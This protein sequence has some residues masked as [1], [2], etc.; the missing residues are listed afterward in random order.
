MSATPDSTLAD[1]EQLIADLQRQLAE[2][3]AERDEALAA[4]DRDRRG[5]AGHQFLARRPRAGV[6][7]DARKGDA[8]VRGRIRHL[9]AYDGEHFAPC[10]ARRVRRLAECMRASRRSRTGTPAARIV[11]GERSCTLPMSPTDALSNRRPRRACRSISAA[12]ARCLSCRCA[13]MTLCSAVSSVYRQ[14]VRPFSDKQIALLQNFAAQA[15]IAMENARLITE[16]REALGAADRDRRGLAGHQF[17]ARRPRAGVRRDARKGDA[18][19]A[20][21]V[22]HLRTYDGER[23]RASRCA[24]CPPAF[25]EFGATARTSGPGTDQRA[26]FSSGERLSTSPI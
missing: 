4:A 16:T 3:T 1:P 2:R 26:A 6:R 11:A 22:R 17:L 14:E 9:W 8:A 20:A 24:A 13:R 15:V 23:F 10:D 7:C 18:A 21:P 19:C 12:R 25:A 5:V